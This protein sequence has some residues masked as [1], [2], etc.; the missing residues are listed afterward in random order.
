MDEPA[1]QPVSKEAVGRV[2]G[3]EDATPLEFWVALAEG[4]YLQLDDVVVCERDVAGRATRVS[5]SG[6]VTQVRARHE[7]AKFDSDV[8]LIEDGVLPAGAGG[9]GQGGPTRGGARDFVPPPPRPPGAPGGGGGRGGGRF[10]R[11][12]PP[13]V[14]IGPG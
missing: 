3:T 10:F 6:V 12:K 11:P 7:G 8:F 14:A 13:Q 5:V 9:A 4:Q 2:L 1:F